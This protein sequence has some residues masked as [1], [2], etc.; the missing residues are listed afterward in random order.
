MSKVICEKAELTAVA[1]AIRAKT[2]TTAAMSLGEMATNIA[3]ISGGGGIID[4]TEL[5]TENIV[6]NVIYRVSSETAELWLTN[7][8]VP[9]TMPLADYMAQM[10]GI[11]PIFVIEMVDALP[12]ELTPI[13]EN[14]FTF[15][16]YILNDTGVAYINIDGEVGSFATMLF[17]DA[18]FDKGWTNDIAAETEVGIYS[19]RVAINDRYVYMDGK[20]VL[21]ETPTEPLKYTLSD[22]GTHYIVAANT[23][24]LFGII[25]IPSTYNDLPVTE[26]AAYGFNGCR[27]ITAVQIPESITIMGAS[28][29]RECTGLSEILGCEGVTTIPSYCF[30]G[31]TNLSFDFS[32]SNVTKIEDSAFRRCTSATAFAKLDNLESIG[33]EAFSQCSAMEKTFFGEANTYEQDLRIPASVQ[34]IES[35]AFWRCWGLAKIRFLGTPTSISSNAFDSIDG[36]IYVP[37]AEG[38]VAGAP[39]GAT[40]AT[41]HY[42]HTET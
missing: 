36:D 2:D 22:D 26:I 35:Y 8:S 5:P 40:R 32:L 19:V 42:N 34:T 13:D 17:G 21:I 9:A 3:S 6:E 38:A 39:W 7:P 33:T 29:F 15:Y 11:T 23:L 41:I 12:N 14:T 1:D 31:C 20:W 10:M 37:W 24:E 28:A 4:V 30:Y 18:T 16:I 25:T 27:G